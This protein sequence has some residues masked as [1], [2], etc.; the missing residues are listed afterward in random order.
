VSGSI[1]TWF[2]VTNRKSNTSWSA[3]GEGSN[4]VL[5]GGLRGEKEAVVQDP[6]ETLNTTKTERRKIPSSR[7]PLKQK[8]IVEEKKVKTSKSGYARS[9]VLG[10]DPNK[11]EKTERGEHLE[12]GSA[13]NWQNHVETDTKKKFGRKGTRKESP[14]EVYIAYRQMAKTKL[15]QTDEGPLFT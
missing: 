12:T 11:S 4:G 7:G 5:G 6:T 14:K 2:D 3:T 10:L 15:T 1:K 8:T 9:P 13:G